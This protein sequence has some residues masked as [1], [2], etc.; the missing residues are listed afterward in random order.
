MYEDEES[1]LAFEDE[2]GIFENWDL[3]EEDLKFRE[4]L[5]LDHPKITLVDPIKMAALLEGDR[6]L[7]R[8][9]RQRKDV[10]VCCKFK[11]FESTRGILRLVG[12][13]FVF[14]DPKRILRAVSKADMVE[15]YPRKG[16]GMAMVAT[17]NCLSYPLNWN[18]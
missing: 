1:Q 8:A 12:P 18:H 5:T 4:E 14:L 3:T 17:Y 13:R 11:V 9:F 7:R 6:V 2:E 15:F 10:T 16:N